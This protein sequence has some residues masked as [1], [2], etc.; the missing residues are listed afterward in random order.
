MD[1]AVIAS[2]VKW[3]NV[4]D[5]YGWLHLDAHGRWLLGE[6]PAKSA[7]TNGAAS[8][9][10]SGAALPSAVE[11]EG[12]KAFINRNYGASPSGAWALQN[13][14]QRVW[15]TLALAPLIVGLHDGVAT[16]HTGAVVNINT[17][18]L[19]DAGVVYFTTDAGPAALQSASMNTFSSTVH[20][21]DLATAHWQQH[22][23]APHHSIQACTAASVEALL[24]FKRQFK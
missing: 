19:S 21:D 22:A 8:G 7:D 11:H 18:Y 4:P 12:L 9:A 20:G 16:A 14:P 1:D 24:G 13:G 23:S 17:V 2:M 3:P 5:C 15:V 6:L 10:A